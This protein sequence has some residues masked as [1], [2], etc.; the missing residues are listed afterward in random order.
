MGRPEVAAAYEQ[1]RLRYELARP[2]RCCGN[3]LPAGAGLLTW[4]RRPAPRAS[5]R[6]GAAGRPP[7]SRRAARSLVRLLASFACQLARSSMLSGCRVRT[8]LWPDGLARRRRA[9]EWGRR[10]ALEWVCKES[11]HRGQVDALSRRS[12]AIVIAGTD[13]AVSMLAVVTLKE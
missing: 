10:R 12:R 2:A 3:C 8:R 4:W 6:Q 5:A 13:F 11:P 7:R 1:T 9:L